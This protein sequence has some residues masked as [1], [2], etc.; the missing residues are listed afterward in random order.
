MRRGSHH[1]TGGGFPEST[2]TTGGT[3][4]GVEIGAF[5]FVTTFQPDAENGENGE[6]DYQDDQ[7]DDP[8]IVGA[9]PRFV[10]LG[11]RILG[12]GV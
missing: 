12:R 11:G 7:H 9:P 1:A 6:A 10:F 4:T 2:T 3:R 5:S 8:L